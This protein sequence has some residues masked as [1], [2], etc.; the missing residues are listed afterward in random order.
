MRFSERRLIDGSEC[1][2]LDMGYETVTHRHR[3]QRWKYQYPRHIRPHVSTLS[4]LNKISLDYIDS[5]IMVNQGSEAQF[6]PISTQ[7]PTTV[8]VHEVNFIHLGHI[9][10]NLEQRLK[11]AQLKGDEWLINLLEKEFQEMGPLCVIYSSHI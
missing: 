4:E 9:C 1:N 7:T 6:C 3:G 2:G 11:K 5:R 10:R 8:D